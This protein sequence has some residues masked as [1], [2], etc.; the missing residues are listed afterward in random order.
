[1][2]EVFSANH[3]VSLQFDFPLTYMDS[4]TGSSL[5]GVCS[6]VSCTPPVRDTSVPVVWQCFGQSLLCERRVWE[7]HAVR[8]RSVRH[9]PDKVCGAVGYLRTAVTKLGFSKA[10]QRSRDDWEGLIFRCLP[11]SDCIFQTA[12]GSRELL[13]IP[14]SLNSFKTIDQLAN[15]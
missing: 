9:I 6:V 4:H 10:D 2:A 1:M 7:A 15:S 14:S 12:A 8:S 3:N 13:S 11:A 5:V